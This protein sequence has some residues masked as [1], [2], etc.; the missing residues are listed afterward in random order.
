MINPISREPEEMATSLVFHGLYPKRRH[1]CSLELQ[2]SI[3][4]RPQHAPRDTHWLEQRSLSTL[5]CLLIN[6]RMSGICL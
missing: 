1:L 4:P 2:K 3:R 5:I 6:S